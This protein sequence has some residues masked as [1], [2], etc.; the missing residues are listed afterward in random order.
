MGPAGLHVL[1]LRFMMNDEAR[2]ASTDVDIKDGGV[3]DIHVAAIA[4]LGTIG[5]L[6]LVPCCMLRRSTPSRLMTALWRRSHQAMLGAPGRGGRYIDSVQEAAQVGSWQGKK[7]LFSCEGNFLSGKYGICWYAS[8]VDLDM[9]MGPGPH[10]HG[11]C[12]C[13]VTPL[14]G[15]VTS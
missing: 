13:D 8:T 7:D 9:S 6:A 14:S 2:D 11:A 3:L 15:G 5:A 1:L 4:V 12:V 10:I